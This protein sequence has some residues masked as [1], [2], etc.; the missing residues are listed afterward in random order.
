MMPLPGPKGVKP[1]HLL[2]P[3]MQGIISTASPKACTS[4]DFF[5]LQPH[6]SIL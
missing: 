4:V 3:S 1:D 2:K 6:T 5:R